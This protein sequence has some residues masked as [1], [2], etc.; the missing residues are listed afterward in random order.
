MPYIEWQDWMTVGVPLV[1]ADHK[2]L[3]D[4]INQVHDCLGKPEET[5]NLGSILA[6]LCDYTD[7]HFQ[8]E[9]KLQETVGYPGLVGHRA[10]HASLTDQV[11]E[12]NRRFLAQPASVRG[13]DVLT[14]LERW[15][16]NHII[17]QDMAFRPYALGNGAAEAT[18]REAV[19]MGQLRGETPAVAPNWS[20]FSILVV[21]D[22]VNFLTLMETVLLGVGAVKVRTAQS[23]AL[24]LE[25]LAANAVDIVVVDRFMIGMDGFEFLAALRKSQDP[26][27][28]QTGVLMISGRGDEETM[29]R[30][31]RTG[32]DEFLE[33]P[34]SAKDLLA[35]MARIVASRR[36]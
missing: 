24:G 28:A 32:A 5:I 19:T 33:K 20:E 27:V 16:I 12:I 14:F 23:A 11:N 21:D 34:L 18:A 22:N 13:I 7:Y 17:N 26:I 29:R 3:L 9:E 15:L 36:K 6:A 8:R 1:D 4:L 35:A 25:Y 2:L 10:M 31:L 30:A